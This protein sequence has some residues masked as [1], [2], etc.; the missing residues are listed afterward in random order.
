MPPSL[1]HE[2]VLVLEEQRRLSSLLIEQALSDSARKALE[3]E[4]H[5]EKF[6]SEAHRRS[7][8][9]GKAKGERIVRSAGGLPSAAVQRS[10]ASWAPN[11]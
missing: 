10:H 9:E 2:G 1:S 3:M 7:Y 4:P 6:F 11:A 5:I 8:A